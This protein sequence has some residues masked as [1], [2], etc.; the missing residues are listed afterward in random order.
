MAAETPDNADTTEVRVSFPTGAAAGIEIL[1]VGGVIKAAGADDDR[2]VREERAVVGEEVDDSVS[3]TITAE[4]GSREITITF[5]EAV[6]ASPNTDIFRFATSVL[7][8]DH[9]AIAEPDSGGRLGDRE[10]LPAGT[11]IVYV[12]TPAIPATST[13]PEVAATYVATITL[14][15]GEGLA[16]FAVFTII[17]NGIGAVRDGGSRRVNGA[18]FRVDEAREITADIAAVAGQGSFTVTFS[19]AVDR[20]P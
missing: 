5:S 11:T 15:V 16:N 13:T 9:Y 18:S 1:V 17:N 12:A 8:A 19:E 2:R 20:T 10:P 14:P 6:N 3:A 4:A 7:D